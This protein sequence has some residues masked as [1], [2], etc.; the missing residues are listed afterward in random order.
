MRKL[1]VFVVASIVAVGTVRLADQSPG[2]TGGATTQ[3]DLVL[4]W[5]PAVRDISRDCHADMQPGVSLSVAISSAC[6]KDSPSHSH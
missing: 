3:D 6:A 2:R 4:S 5:S 1:S